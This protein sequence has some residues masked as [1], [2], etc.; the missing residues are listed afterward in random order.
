MVMP[1]WRALRRSVAV[2]VI[3]IL[4]LIGSAGAIGMGALTF[5]GLL[6]GGAAPPKDFSGSLIFFRAIMLL[7]PLIYILPGVWGIVTAIGLLQLKNWARISIIIFSV[8]LLAFGLITAL[9]SSVFFLAN[10]PPGMDRQVVALA[11]VVMLMLAA[12]QIGLGVWWLVFFNRAKVKEQFVAPSMFAGYPGAPAGYPIQP[13]YHAQPPPAASGAVAPQAPQRS[14][15]P[16]SITIIACFMLVGCLFY[17]IGVA[18][19]SPAA[20]FVW[21]LTG[22]EALGFSLIVVALTIYVG[23]GLLRLNRYA[24]LTGIGY[25]AFFSANA[26]VFYF[27][28]GGHSRV[29]KLVE[30]QQSLFPALRDMQGAAPPMDPTPFIWMGGA[31]GIALGVVQIYFLITRKHAFEKPLAP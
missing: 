27:A 6:A 26:A 11:R 8:L 25:V 23:V 31:I 21:V 4:A 13:S 16:V 3:A 7:V 30:L 29:M 10:R 19:R 28:P 15:R 24:R 1:G 18:L 5:V 2:T 12:G 20:L 17:S 22:R 14:Q 9:S